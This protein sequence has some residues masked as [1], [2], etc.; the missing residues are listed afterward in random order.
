MDAEQQRQQQ[1]PGAAQAAATAREAE[2][3]GRLDAASARGDLEE[4]T[5]LARELRAAE[6]RRALG[7]AVARREYAAVERLGSELQ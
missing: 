6:L 3:Q 5:A 7:E 2:L 4:V 1:L